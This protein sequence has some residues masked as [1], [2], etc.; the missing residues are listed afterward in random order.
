MEG[1]IPY[2]IE[3]RIIRPDGVI[4]HIHAQGEVERDKAGQPKRMAGTLLDITERILTQQRLE[5]L[6]AEQKALVENDLVGIMKAQNRTIIWANTAFEKMLGYDPGELIGVDTR[7]AYPSD[8]T[9]QAFGTEAYAVLATGGVYRSETEY[10]RKDGKT[11]W[12]DV[13][14]AMLDAV[15][16]KSLWCF[17]EITERKYAEQVLSRESEK[18]RA[19]LR[20]ASDGITIINVDG[21]IVEVSDSF[22]AMLGYARDELI[23]MHVS[24]WDCGFNSRDEM[25]A[26]FSQQF[27]VRTRSLFESRHRRKD[28]SIYDVEISGFPIELGGQLLVFNSSRDITER[29]QADI[30][31]RAAKEAAEAA[32]IAKS[33]FLATMSHEI[34]TPMN[35]ILGMANL[36]LLPNQ[37]DAERLSFARTILNSGQCLMTLLNDSR[38]ADFKSKFFRLHNGTAGGHVAAASSR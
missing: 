14:G 10:V 20:N 28:G 7:L 6:L 3:Y 15:T 12:A 27:K 32:N 25:M 33:R 21:Y 37:K 22:C 23:G 11:I 36:L 24:Q 26:A 29:K 8:E 31:L 19:L 34:R 30:A 1:E 4:R 38:F 35:G 18:N 9:Y 2:S 5:N 17:V 16:G 13:S